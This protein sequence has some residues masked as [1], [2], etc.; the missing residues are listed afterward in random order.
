MSETTCVRIPLRCL[1][2]LPA[3]AL[4][5]HSA[6]FAGSGSPIATAAANRGVHAGEVEKTRIVLTNK[7][8]AGHFAGE[9]VR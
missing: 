2:S 8:R 7:G 9:K 3:P 6:S 1:A 4:S 5:V